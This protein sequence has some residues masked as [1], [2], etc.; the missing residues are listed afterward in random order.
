MA[1]VLVR[2]ASARKSGRVLEKNEVMIQC[3]GWLDRRIGSAN[4]NGCDND[5]QLR[6]DVWKLVL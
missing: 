3:D 5:K 4:G 2:G 1:R 6:R